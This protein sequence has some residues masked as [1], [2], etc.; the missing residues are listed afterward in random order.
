MDTAPPNNSTL[1]DNIAGDIPTPAKWIVNLLIII[2]EG[3][4]LAL[5]W[6]WLVVPL[7]L[8]PIGIANAIGL[9]L[10]VSLV[11]FKFRASSKETEEVTFRLKITRQLAI[12]AYVLAFAFVLHLYM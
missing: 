7:G 6:Y 1:R 10:I 2:A 9:E 4:L 3:T 11:A 8:P 12:M 5:L